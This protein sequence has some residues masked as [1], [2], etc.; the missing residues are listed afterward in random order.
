MRFNFNKNL[1]LDEIVHFFESASLKQPLHSFQL[2]DLTIRSREVIK[3]KGFL[4]RY[5]NVWVNTYDDLIEVC[6]NIKNGFVYDDVVYSALLDKKC[7]DSI[8]NRI[9]NDKNFG[10]EKYGSIIY[11]K[12]TED[13]PDNTHYHYEE[14]LGQ[15]EFRQRKNSNGYLEYDKEIIECETHIDGIEIKK[16]KTNDDFIKIEL[17][18]NFNKSE[19]EQEKSS[20]QKLQYVGLHNPFRMAMLDRSHKTNILELK[21]DQN[22]QVQNLYYCGD[23]FLLQNNDLKDL[24]F[25]KNYKQSLTNLNSSELLDSSGY[26]KNIEIGSIIYKTI[27]SQLYK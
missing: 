14:L 27:K 13:C 19:M 3:R 26:K 12:N 11:G 5:D 17:I 7:S 16:T 6:A 18:Y 20:I 1:D 10:K 4:S 15:K 22:E 24:I 23:G 25:F 2:C 9:N 21:V 8:I